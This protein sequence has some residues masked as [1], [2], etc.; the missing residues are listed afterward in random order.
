MEFNAIPGVPFTVGWATVPI[1]LAL[2]SST[3]FSTAL[4]RSGDE[5]ADS[6]SVPGLG[7]DDA[8]RAAP[9][10]VAIGSRAIAVARTMGA[11]CFRNK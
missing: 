5:D 9:G 2:P 10:G 11:R 4:P 6:A 8:H 3:K 1:L 7:L